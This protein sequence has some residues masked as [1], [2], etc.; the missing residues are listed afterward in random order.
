[1]SQ[2]EGLSAAKS[3]IAKDS[4]DLLSFQ[5]VS[6][7]LMRCSEALWR[8][9][10]SGQVAHLSHCLATWNYS[11]T[12]FYF[13]VL[14]FLPIDTTSMF[15]FV[16][17]FKNLKHFSFL[18]SSKN[19]WLF[20]SHR[21]PSCHKLQQAAVT[22]PA[23]P[24]SCLLSTQSCS[25]TLISAHRCVWLWWLELSDWQTAW[26]HWTDGG[27]QVHEVNMWAERGLVFFMFF[28]GCRSRLT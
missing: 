15:C 1:M 13:V 6:F 19:N 27:V 9:A 28:C 8:F 20:L 23:V 4:N 10:P 22:R 16:F 25:A 26:G 7:C 12:S 3:K 24:V 21:G 18:L 14:F 2:C 11:S 5:W 17:F